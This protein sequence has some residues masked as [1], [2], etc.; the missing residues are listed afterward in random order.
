MEK[1]EGQE[2]RDR[3]DAYFRIF[4]QVHGKGER[5]CPGGSFASVFDAV[6]SPVK[7]ALHRF[8]KQHLDLLE[9]IIREGV[10]CGQFNIGDQRPRDVATQIVAGIQGALLVGRLTGDSHL[11]DQV[12]AELRIYLGY[13]GKD[14]VSGLGPETRH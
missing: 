7:S 6:S 12:V 2:P 1:T 9:D 5:M 13:A 10:A 4:R 11:V 3:L 14:R 8:S